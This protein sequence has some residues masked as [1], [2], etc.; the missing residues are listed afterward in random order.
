MITGG[1]DDPRYFMI[2][3]FQCNHQGYQVLPHN[4]GGRGCPRRPENGIIVFFKEVWG[5]GGGGRGD[6]L[7]THHQRNK[8]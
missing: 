3:H 2:L 6:I 5:G 7:W 1:K 4:D 8:S